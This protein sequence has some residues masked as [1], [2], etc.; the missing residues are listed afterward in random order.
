MK[1]I[2]YTLALAS[3]FYNCGGKE[4]KKVASETP[5]SVTVQPVTE[6]NNTPFVSASGKIE[7]VNSATLST[8]M[9][10]FVEAVPVKV[11]QKV[12]QGDVIGTVGSTGR[13]TGPHLDVRLNWFDVRLDPATVL[14]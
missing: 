11:G 9:M 12:K 5:I 1:K 7:A 14:N 10:G 4:P 2:L 6:T 13:A 3:L 8:R